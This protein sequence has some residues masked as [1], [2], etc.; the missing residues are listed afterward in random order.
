L[1]SHHSTEREISTSGSTRYMR[2]IYIL[3]ASFRQ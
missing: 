1:L 3:I 2:A